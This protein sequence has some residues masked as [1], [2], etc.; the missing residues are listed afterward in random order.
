MNLLGLTPCPCIF[1]KSCIAFFVCPS[2]TYFVSFWIHAKGFNCRM[3]GAIAAISVAPH[4]RVRQLSSQSTSLV[5]VRVKSR[6]LSFVYKNNPDQAD[7]PCILHIPGI[8]VIIRTEK[9]VLAFSISILHLLKSEPPDW[10]QQRQLWLDPQVNSDRID[11]QL[12]SLICDPTIVMDLK[13]LLPK[14]IS[15]M[16]R[17]CRKT[18]LQII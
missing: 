15:L 1:L 3:P 14:S 16:S 12:P 11:V 6:C 18:S 5:C 4:G 10:H 8:D 9:A 13:E 7:Q 17:N 2:F